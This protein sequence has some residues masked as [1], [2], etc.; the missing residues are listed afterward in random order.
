[1]F[2]GLSKNFFML[3][4][5][6]FGLNYQASHAMESWTADTQP[7]PQNDPAY[8]YNRFKLIFWA[9]A[10]RII[11]VDQM[12]N[13]LL[14]N[15]LQGDDLQESDLRTVCEELEKF[16]DGKL[17]D[18]VLVLKKLNKIRCFLAKLSRQFAVFYNDL[19]G[20]IPSYNDEELGPEAAV[21]LTELE[22]FISE[23][24]RILK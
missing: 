5:L 22:K 11:I 9:D 10:T 7:A 12:E 3:C 19:Y 18:K 24:E 4:I 15:D 17:A 1:M 13:D 2:N 21:M 6:T 16:K 20:A 8:L 14:E 23:V